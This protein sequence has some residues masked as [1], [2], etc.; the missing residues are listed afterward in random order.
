MTDD[1]DPTEAIDG[2]VTPL[3]DT[4]P[5]TARERLAPLAESLSG[6]TLVG[7]GEATH[8]THEFV[9]IRDGLVRALVADHG[10]R[11]LTMEVG[12]SAGLAL[13]RYVRQG[14]GDPEAALCDLGLWVWATEELRD[15]LEWLRAFNEDRPADDRVRVLGF[16]AP[17]VSA[18]AAGLRDYLDRVDPETLAEVRDGLDL[19]ADGDVRAVPFPL[20]AEH[21]PVAEETVSTLEARFDARG[22]EWVERSGTGPYRLARGHLRTLDDAVAFAA[23]SHRTDA[24]WGARDLRDER[25]ADGVRWLLD[26]A[27][28]D[29][30]VVWAH[31]GHLFR[32]RTDGPWDDYTPMGRHLHERF[33]DEYRVVATAFDRGSL[34]AFED[35]GTVDRPEPVVFRLG[36]FADV[37]PGDGSLPSPTVGEVLADAAG[38]DGAVGFD[39][40]RAAEDSELEGWLSAPHPVRDVTAAFFGEA[41]HWWSLT[42][43]AEADA[44]VFVPETTPVTL[45]ADAP[46][47]A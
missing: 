34:R 26:L 24:P 42:L 28:A 35:P 21:V 15:L 2:Y 40:R 41:E 16:D 9:T 19:L 10:F 12:F 17:S 45:L 4:D 23:E 27:G 37:L 33:G 3:P 29:R 39:V 7:L 22:A 44:L 20:A 46:R 47:H 32:G 5:V 43:P 38:E 30:A 13:D 18:P 31:N 14:S 36:P 6:A 1:T 8:G 11:L 25:M